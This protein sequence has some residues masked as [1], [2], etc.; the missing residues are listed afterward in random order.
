MEKLTSV[1][2][3]WEAPNVLLEPRTCLLESPKTLTLQ[4]MTINAK[5]NP[6]IH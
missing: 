3:R 6:I 5:L 1:W 4:V 2:W